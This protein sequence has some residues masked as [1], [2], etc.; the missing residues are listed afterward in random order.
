MKPPS[1]HDSSLGT[2]RQCCSLVVYESLLK[3]VSTFYMSFWFFLFV[4]WFGGAGVGRL[5]W[6]DF[7]FFGT[8]LLC[9]ALAVLELALQS[10]LAS[11]SQRS[12][13]LCLLSARI[14]GVHHH[15]LA[16]KWVLKRSYYCFVRALSVFWILFMSDPKLAITFLLT[17]EFISTIYALIFKISLWWSPYSFKDHQR[18]LC[19]IQDD[20]DFPQEIFNFTFWSLMH[21]MLIFV[22][23][24]KQARVCFLFCMCVFSCPRLLK[25]TLPS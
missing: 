18:N 7:C 20:W 10:R 19:L 17:C 12:S 25:D 6:F 3:S 2:K 8:R 16:F 22:D 13:C 23:Q 1:F 5:F 4:C 11:N 14:K 21:F 24:V 9:V 15:H